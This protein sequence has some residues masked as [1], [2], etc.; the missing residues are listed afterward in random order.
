MSWWPSLISTVKTSFIG[1][2]HPN[3]LQPLLFESVGRMEKHLLQSNQ[4]FWNRDGHTGRKLQKHMIAQGYHYRFFEGTV[5]L[6]AL[7]SFLHVGTIDRFQYLL[8][9]AAF[10]CFD[11]GS[12]ET[13]AVKKD[14]VATGIHCLSYMIACFRV[15]SHLNPKH[16]HPW[17]HVLQKPFRRRRSEQSSHWHKAL[18]LLQSQSHLVLSVAVPLLLAWGIIPKTSWLEW[19]HSRLINDIC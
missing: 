16:R 9:K 1:C 10:A 18:A 13:D 11:H 7:D 2:S 17:D 12:F 8:T 5:A 19:H 15:F 3:T 4:T 6:Y 14:D